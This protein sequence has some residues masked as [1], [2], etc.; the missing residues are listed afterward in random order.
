MMR[1]RDSSF[2]LV[3]GISC[4]LAVACGA[5]GDALGGSDEWG[6]LAVVAE[7]MGDRELVAGTLE[8]SDECV[9]L[10]ERGH[11]RYL[12][13]WPSDASSWEGGSRGIDFDSPSGGQ[14]TVHDT[15]RVS[16]TGAEVAEL[17]S[18]E[19]VNSPGSGCG[20]DTVFVVSDVTDVVVA[21]DEFSSPDDPIGGG[22]G[23]TGVNVELQC[24]PDVESSTE[25]WYGPVGLTLDGAVAEAFGDLVVG[26]LGEPFEIETT[27]SWSSW[28][29]DDDIG[30]LVAVVTVVASGGGWDPSHA[31]YCVIPQPTPPPPPFTLYVSNQSFEEPTV[32][33][34]IQ[35]DDQVVV[36]EGFDVEGQHNWITFTPDVTPGDHTL[37][38]VSDTGAEFSVDFTIPE[39]EPRWAVVDYWYYPEEGP[40]SFTFDISDQPIGF[41]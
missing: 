7:P 29:L 30:N 31:Q 36:D 5:V 41:D 1:I 27:E 39:N 34:T 13:A 26:W 18:V 21:T 2:V 19:W 4:L 40:R 32:R 24:P 23:G 28:G 14:L 6:P 15:N 3:L 17:S 35:I 33:I 8:V 16:V 37:Q 12:V 11:R 22:L 9:I 20:A 10:D 38:A 25:E